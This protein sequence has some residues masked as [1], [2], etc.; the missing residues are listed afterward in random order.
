[1]GLTVYSVSKQKPPEDG[2]LRPYWDPK[3]LLPRPYE[4]R[5]QPL[6]FNQKTHPVK[7]THKC[8]VK[9]PKIHESMIASEV[10]LMM[11]EGTIEVCPGNKAFLTYPSLIIKKNEKSHF[12]MNLKPL[13]QFITCTKLKITTLKEIWEAICPRQWVVL[14]KIIQH[15]GH[16]SKAKRHHCFLCFR[17]RG[18]VY[19]FR[20]LPL[21]PFTT[22]K[23]FM[24]VTKPMLLKCWKMGITVL[25]YLDIALIIVN[26]YTQAREDRQRVVQLLQ[27]EF[28]AEPEKVPS[29]MYSRSYTQAWCST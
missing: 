16:I 1:M 19:Q 22:S 3:S 24:R 15:T 23:T 9:V 2:I 27:T 18:K 7:P 17:W 28:C 5:S 13:N 12:I 10:R 20:I 25:L 11:S 26:S 8:E 29:G 6:Q 4:S 14:L 21:S